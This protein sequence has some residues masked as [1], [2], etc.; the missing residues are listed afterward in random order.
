MANPGALFEAGLQEVARHMGL[1]GAGPDSVMDPTQLRQV[2]ML[3][4][5]IHRV[6]PKHSRMAARP[7]GNLQKEM[8]TAAWSAQPQGSSSSPVALEIYNRLCPCS[9]PCPCQ[10]HQGG[11]TLLWAGCQPSARVAHGS[12][13]PVQ[14]S[15][16]CA[17]L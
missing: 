7:S 4:D 10:R 14:G 11:P 2:R 1:E 13:E 9:Y 15:V 5:L 12:A 8:G 6:F 17:A 3:P 16:A